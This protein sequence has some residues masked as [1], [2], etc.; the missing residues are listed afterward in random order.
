MSFYNPILFF[1]IN[2]K[3]SIDPQFV[4]ALA[5]SCDSIFGPFQFWRQSK[6]AP[7]MHDPN[8]RAL[9]SLKN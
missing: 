4:V 7:K 9:W 3:L 2:L 5:L 8:H 6:P 1:C